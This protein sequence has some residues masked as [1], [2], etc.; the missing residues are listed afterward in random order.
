MWV[1]TTDQCKFLESGPS[2]LIFYASRTIVEIVLSPRTPPLFGPSLEGVRS[3]GK[4]FNTFW[5][6]YHGS[7]MSTLSLTLGRV[8]S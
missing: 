5:R 4:G 3:K 1:A 2:S 7:G 8:T 6:L